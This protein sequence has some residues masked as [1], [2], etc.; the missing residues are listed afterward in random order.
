MC[1]GCLSE[2]STSPTCLVWRENCLSEQKWYELWAAIF[3][4]HRSTCTKI[5]IHMLYFYI[6]KECCFLLLSLTLWILFFLHSQLHR[7]TVT[8]FC[9]V[10][11]IFINKFLFEDMFYFIKSIKLN[12]YLKSMCI[13]CYINDQN[14][15]P[16]VGLQHIQ[17]G[18]G[19]F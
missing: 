9:Q 18:F 7:I 13:L 4:H 1:M 12:I 17:P 8:Y 15:Q 6:A 5:Q 2:T 14:L 19:K 3:L 16:F 11:D 10:T